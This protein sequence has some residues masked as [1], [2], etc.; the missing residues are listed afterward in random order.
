VDLPETDFNE[1]DA[2][3]NVAHPVR[4]GIRVIQP[5]VDPIALL[6][7]L[8]SVSVTAVGGLLV[9]LAAIPTQRHQHSLQDLLCT[10]LI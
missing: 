4:P 9:A 10:F 2:P 8:P 7:T 5:A 3:V 6:P 1:A